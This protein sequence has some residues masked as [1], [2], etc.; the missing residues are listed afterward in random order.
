MHQL[1]KVYTSNDDGSDLLALGE[2]SIVLS[3]GKKVDGNLIARLV[4]VNVGTEDVRVKYFQ[5]WGVRNNPGIFHSPV[6][7]CQCPLDVHISKI[8]SP[9]LILGCTGLRADAEGVA[10]GRVI[11]S[12][13]CQPRRPAGI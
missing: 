4:L 12:V 13:P 5:V 11:L 6:S 9:L 1:V 2:A 8:R 3:N 10:G 7:G